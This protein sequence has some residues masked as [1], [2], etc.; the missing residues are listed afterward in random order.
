MSIDLGA[1]NLPPTPEKP[2]NAILA[3]VDAGRMTMPEELAG[4]RLTLSES[5]PERLPQLRFTVLVGCAG[6][7][8]GALAATVGA[9]FV[10]TRKEPVAHVKPD[11]VRSLAV[12]PLENLVGDTGPGVSWPMA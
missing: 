1:M 8:V 12:L 5:K 9:Y 2:A 7:L 4:T 11:Q 3:R 6:L 10:P